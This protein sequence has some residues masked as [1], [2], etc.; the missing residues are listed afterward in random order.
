MCLVRPK[1][2][3]FFGL[4]WWGKMWIR[5]KKTTAFIYRLENE[6]VNVVHDK[7]WE[8][9]QILAQ[10]L[11]KGKTYGEIE[12]ID[13]QL[14]CMYVWNSKMLKVGSGDGVNNNMPF[15]RPH[16][17]ILKAPDLLQWAFSSL[18]CFR[19]NIPSFLLLGCW[20]IQCPLMHI[21]HPPRPPYL[22]TPPQS[23]MCIYIYISL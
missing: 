9:Y 4:I 11:D 18:H 16:K 19:V 23:L 14:L 5:M 21:T 17:C 12:K 13:Q 3:F 15:P 2:F 10:N 7:S 6:N 20:K 22:H 8:D 1:N